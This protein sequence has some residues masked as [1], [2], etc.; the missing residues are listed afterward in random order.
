[1]QHSGGCGGWPTRHRARETSVPDRAPRPLRSPAAHRRSAEFRPQPAQ[2]LSLA[3]RALL[4]AG[5]LALPAGPALPSD[6]AASPWLADPS[7]DFVVPDVAPAPHTPGVERVRGRTKADARDE[8]DVLV[9]YT[10]AAK[11]AVGGDMDA[12][13]KRLFAVSAQA[14][15][16]SEI[17]TRLRLVHAFEDADYDDAA[18]AGLHASLLRSDGDGFLDAVHPLRNEH[19]ADVVVL[20]Y[21]YQPGMRGA[22]FAYLGAPIDQFAFAAAS[23]QWPTTFTHEVSHLLAAGHNPEAH[24]PGRANPRFPDGHGL[25]NAQTGWRTIM[26]YNTAGRCPR[27]ITH[28]SNPDV[29]YEGTPTGDL[30][31]RNNARVMNE[32]A[33]RVANFRVRGSIIPPTIHHRRVWFVPGADQHPLQGLVR[34]RNRA[35]HPVEVGITAYDETG[36]LFGP[37]SLTIPARRTLGLTSSD[38]E[39]GNDAK[40]LNAGLGNGQGS[41]SLLLKFTGWL[42]PG[43]SRLEAHAYVRAPGGHLASVLATEPVT[44]VSVPGPRLYHQEFWTSLFNPASN[45]GKRSRLRIVPWYS[46]SNAQRL[47]IVGW[48]SAGNPAEST[49][50]VL[51]VPR[52]NQALEFSARALEAGDP[53]R[54]AGRLGDGEG[55]WRLRVRIPAGT[56][57]PVMS[58]MDNDEGRLTNLSGPLTVSQTGPA[59]LVG[60]LAYIPGWRTS[61]VNGFV[62]LQNPSDTEATVTVHALDDSG[63]RFGPATLTVPAQASTGFD[64]RDLEHGNAARGLGPGVG[65]GEGAWHLEIHSDNDAIVARAFARSPPSVLAEMNAVAPH[66]WVPGRHY[67][68]RY[69]VPFFNPGSNRGIQSLLRIVNVGPRE[70]HIRVFAWDDTGAPAPAGPVD[71]VLAPDAAVMLSAQQLEAGDESAFSGRFGDGTG[72]WRL[73]VAMRDFHRDTELLVMSLVRAHGGGLTNVSL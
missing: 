3:A 6:S 30:E 59:T 34:L 16:N 8:I 2:G 12:H 42:L 38:L 41:W 10:S 70:N 45:Q 35:P 26:A 47:E 14:Y 33:E 15:A 25:C 48:D 39:Q 13:L 50:R 55:K 7:V 29:L 18:D 5:T 69:A 51:P 46:L 36:E 53:E 54:F 40:G 22:G 61:G 71:L 63:A 4:A 20:L 68:V 21:A 62:R 57:L 56:R 60:R 65:D 37:V 58:L 27:E 1:M 9:V 11:R 17:T 52:G 23:V 73:E 32:R 44:R 19:W 24:P 49:V 67:D 31:Q 28:L 64:A 66:L 43:P 72:K